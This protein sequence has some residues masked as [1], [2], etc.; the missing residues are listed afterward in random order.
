MTL[1]A[2]D[3]LLPYQSFPE[4]QEKESMQG[5][6]KPPLKISLY[7]FCHILLSTLCPKANSGLFKG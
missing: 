7:Y 1:L 4:T 5:L 2:P 3:V 6:L